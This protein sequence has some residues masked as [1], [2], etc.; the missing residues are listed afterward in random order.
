MKLMKG[1]KLVKNGE[2]MIQTPYPE[3]DDLLE[4]MG[5]A[6]KRLSEIEASEGAAVSAGDS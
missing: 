3:I 4:M 1:F 6:G 2:K 5:E